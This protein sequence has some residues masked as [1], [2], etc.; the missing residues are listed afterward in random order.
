L[1]VIGCDFNQSPYRYAKFRATAP[2][3][4]A[5][6]MMMMMTTTTTDENR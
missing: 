4:G 3:A 2:V 1:V 6:T 5:A